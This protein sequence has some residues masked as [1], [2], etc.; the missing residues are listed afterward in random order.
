MK[1]LFVLEN[2]LP[3]IGGVEIVFKNLCE[4]LAAQG[5]RVD[6][7]THKMKNTASFEV[8]NCVHVHRIPCFGSRYLFTFLA[9]PKVL[10]LARKADIIH[11][12]TF[13]GAPPAWLA[14]KIA[15]KPVILTVHEVW[16][17]KWKQ[18]TEMGTLQALLHDLLERLIYTLPFSQYVCV[19]H[20]TKTRLD[21]I[22]VPK[23]RSHVIHNGLD[24]TFWNPGRY[25]KRDVQ[26]LQQNL[27][28]HGNFVYLF[29]GRPG[30]S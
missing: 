18:L 21:A 7:I 1:L 9:V 2:Y 17:G 10:E 27:G 12:T 11:T 13:N 22:G 19:S 8:I 4:S 5:H 15:K 24:Y 20:S 3:H 6:I 23:A 16:V 28:M 25:T 26:R 29:Y 14:A 30:V